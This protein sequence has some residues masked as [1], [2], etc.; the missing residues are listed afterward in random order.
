MDVYIE[1]ITFDYVDVSFIGGLHPNRDLCGVSVD[2]TAVVERGRFGGTLDI[3]PSVYV[4]ISDM[5]AFVSAEV[6]G[7]F[8]GVT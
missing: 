8:G 1:S 5:H 3:S 6:R 7:M 4:G 2:F